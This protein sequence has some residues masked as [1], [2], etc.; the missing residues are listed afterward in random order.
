MN[1]SSYI[2]EKKC[3]ISK[4]TGDHDHKPTKEDIVKMLVGKDNIKAITSG[5][6]KKDDFLSKGGA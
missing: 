2:E 5:D 1:S 3:H 6:E 4:L